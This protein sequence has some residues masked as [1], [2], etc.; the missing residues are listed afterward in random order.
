MYQTTPQISLSSSKASLQLMLT[1]S[2]M[3]AAVQQQAEAAALATRLEQQTAAMEAVQLR[4]SA[5]EA[6]S[7]AAAARVAEAQIALQAERQAAA[8][9][10]SS[11]LAVS[12]AELEQQVAAAVSGEQHGSGGRCMGVEHG[13]SGPEAC[14]LAC[15]LSQLAATTK[16]AWMAV[17]LT[18]Q[19]VQG[20]GCMLHAP[21]QG[22]SVAL[23]KLS[24]L[25]HAEHEGQMQPPL[26]PIRSPLAF[27]CQKLILALCREG[28]GGSGAGGSSRGGLC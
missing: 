5:A 13:M 14:E 17:C 19:Q 25:S 9:L 26:A 2:A 8:E 18:Q 16:P 6:E 20:C 28:A 27:R 1:L 7:H 4:A 11:G 10:A 21:L 22:W 23:M 3:Q 12:A 15:I 24:G